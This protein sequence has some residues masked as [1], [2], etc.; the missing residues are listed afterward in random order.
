M[1]TEILGRI[2]NSEKEV[3]SLDLYNEFGRGQSLRGFQ[4]SLADEVKVANLK[5]LENII[6]GNI[7]KDNAFWIIGSKS[8][9][10]YISRD[11]KSAIEGLMGYISTLT[12]EAAYLRKFT[13]F[14]EL[15]HN[16]HYQELLDF[17]EEAPKTDLFI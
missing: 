10:Y 8:G 9:G 6:R 3:K 16:Q 15:V 14:I 2:I 1:K 5:M 13:K 4:R 12:T 17:R 7:H 11:K